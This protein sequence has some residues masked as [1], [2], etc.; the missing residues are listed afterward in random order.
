MN[1]VDKALEAIARARDKLEHAA[2]AI[3]RGTLSDAV[4]IVFEARSWCGAAKTQIE[5]EMDMRRRIALTVDLQ[6][7]RRR[8]VRR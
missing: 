8:G 7:P 6:G 2:A 1:R 4:R 3:E 5:D